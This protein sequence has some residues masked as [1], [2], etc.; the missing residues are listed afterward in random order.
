MRRIR[1]G[2]WTSIHI[3]DAIG[4]IPLIGDVPLFDFPGDVVPTRPD[5][6]VLG[7]THSVIGAVRPAPPLRETL[8][9]GIPRHGSGAGILIDRHLF[10]LTQRGSGSAVRIILVEK[11]HPMPRK[12]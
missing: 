11:R 10:I 7:R 4:G 2:M 8:N 3:D 1:P 5:L 6:L 9:L 12:V